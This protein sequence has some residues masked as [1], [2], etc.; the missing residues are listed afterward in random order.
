MSE[1]N[2]NGFLRDLLDDANNEAFEAVLEAKSSK[3]NSMMES[4]ESMFEARPLAEMQ[5]VWDTNYAQASEAE[6]LEME[7]MVLDIMETR[8]CTADEARH[9]YAMMVQLM[10]L[11]SSPV[12]QRMKPHKGGGKSHRGKRKR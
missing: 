6:R 8:G 10:A 7:E 5:S 12:L 1:L 4:L 9:Y 2:N 11:A 3:I